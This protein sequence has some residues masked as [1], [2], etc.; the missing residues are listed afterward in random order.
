MWITRYTYVGN[1]VTGAGHFVSVNTHPIA[2]ITRWNKRPGVVFVLDWYKE[3]DE[4]EKAILR[5]ELDLNA[6]DVGVNLT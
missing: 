2:M 6:I 4:K 5:E 1:G 3:I